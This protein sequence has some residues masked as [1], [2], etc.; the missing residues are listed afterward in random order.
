MGLVVGCFKIVPQRAFLPQPTHCH[1]VL[2]FEPAKRYRIEPL[3]A[4]LKRQFRSFYRPI[5]QYL[6]WMFGVHWF[7]SIG[8]INGVLNL[9]PVRF[10]ANAA[11]ADTRKVGRGGNPDYFALLS[12]Y[13][14]LVYRGCTPRASIGQTDS[15]PGH[16]A[17]GI[18]G[19][20]G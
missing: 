12:S 19:K 4:H 1:A 5:T 10:A 17:H 6:A 8:S 16:H 9:S 2:K 3:Q 14:R 13:S 15:L 7:M 20:C 11:Q 18:R